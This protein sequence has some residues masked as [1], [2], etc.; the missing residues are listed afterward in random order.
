MN[1]HSTDDPME[2]QLLKIT[3]A[4][5]FC[6]ISNAQENNFLKGIFFNNLVNKLLNKFNL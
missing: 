3:T 6:Q 4:S 1:K 2:R 5:G